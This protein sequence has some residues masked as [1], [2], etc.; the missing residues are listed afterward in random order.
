MPRLGM[1]RD[2]EMS[3]DGGRL[4][5]RGQ[6]TMRTRAAAA[7]GRQEEERRRQVGHERD[8]ELME[9]EENLLEEMANGRQEQVNRREKRHKMQKKKK[10]SKG[11]GKSPW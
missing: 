1:G 7:A 2:E 10:K 5:G 6:G 3:R 8:I 9:C 4:R 11:R